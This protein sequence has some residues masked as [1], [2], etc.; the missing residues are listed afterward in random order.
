MDRK[1]DIRVLHHLIGGV[2]G[3]VGVAEHLRYR[4]DDTRANASFAAWV[5]YARV[6]W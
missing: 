1:S 3:V 2:D 6:R 4:Y 5:P